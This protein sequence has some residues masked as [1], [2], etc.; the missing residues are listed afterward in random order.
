MKNA[1]VEFRNVNLS[2][3]EVN[4]LKDISFSMYSGEVCAFMGENGSGKSS[5]MKILSGAYEKTDGEI[6][7]EG[8]E[9][10]IKSVHDAQSLGIHMI[11]HD[12]QL[13]N[14]FTVCENV[15]LGHEIEYLNLPFVNKKQQAEMLEKIMACLQSGISP[16]ALVSGLNTMEKRF[17]EIA[18]AIILGARVLIFDETAA[19]FNAADK[20]KLFGVIRYLC[21]QGVAIAFISHRMDHVLEISDRII[22][23][24][25]G[26]VVDQKNLKENKA[27]VDDILLK[28]AG[29]DYL[30]RYPKT[31]VK[32]GK[33]VLEARGIG[34]VGGFVH[35]ATLYLRRSEIVGIAG[36]Q[37]TGKTTLARLISG[38]EPIASG[39][40][41]LDGYPIGACSTSEFVHKGIV[42]ISED[43]NVNL[44]MEMD[45]KSN[46]L[47]L[48]VGRRLKVAF[49]EAAQIA[50]YFIDHLSINNT[51]HNSKAKTLSRGTQK[52]VT[53]AKWIQASMRVLVL[54]QPTANLDST[55]KIE[56]Y[57]VLNKL[58]QKET[59][60]IMASSDLSELM[61]MCD[62]IY[63]MY[64]GTIVKEITGAEKSSLL[65]LEYASGKLHDGDDDSKSN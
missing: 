12:V 9:T 50:Q 44:F 32:L 48:D 21:Q 11:Y 26:M 53:L 6:L 58:A 57:N 15:F 36:L 5:M 39:E 20:E 16:G 61:G 28:M 4:V 31:G 35:D 25:E 29:E 37:G 41:L 8:K 24:R 40:I 51:T 2:F 7:F 43:N 55:S 49:K 45:V 19:T 1:L 3:G 65:I 62:R 42:Y 14:N 54:N 64:N 13:V 30:N 38:V 60:I 22:I 27:N 18:K 23:V 10:H 34:S 33:T 46:I 52:K 47:L 59:S 56:L 63:V 17:V